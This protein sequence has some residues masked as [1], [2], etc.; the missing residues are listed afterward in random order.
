MTTYTTTIEG[1][2]NGMVFNTYYTC[3]ANGN[4]T[5]RVELSSTQRITYTQAW[6]VDNRMV[7]IP[8]SVGYTA[9][10][11]YDADGARVMKRSSTDDT[12]YVGNY[13]EKDMTHNVR[14]T[15]YYFGSQRVRS[16]KLMVVAFRLPK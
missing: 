2:N 3:E 14:T 4:M 11:A 10:Y 16:V 7:A 12:F 1:A 8:S 13:L 5:Q 6:D 15:Y 9:T